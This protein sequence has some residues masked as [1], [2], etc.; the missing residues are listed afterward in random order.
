MA[1]ENCNGPALERLCVYCSGARPRPPDTVLTA[2]Q[3]NQRV[4]E[5]ATAALVLLER[6]RS[7]GKPGHQ[8]LA[9]ILAAHALIAEHPGLPSFEWYVAMVAKGRC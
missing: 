4:R 7:I 2:E 5:A 8:A 3:W 6:D 9:Y 1:C